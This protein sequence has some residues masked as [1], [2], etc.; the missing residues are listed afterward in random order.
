MEGRE[1]DDVAIGRRW[2][3]LM[4]K[5]EPLYRI[6]PPIK[7]TMLDKALHACMGN[8]GVVPQIHEGWRRL[9]RSKGGCGEAEATDL[10]LRRQ[11]SK[12]GRSER[13]RRRNG[14]GK[15]MVL[16]CKNMKGEAATYR[17]ERGE[18]ANHP[19]RFTRSLRRVTSPPSED[20]A[21]AI[22]SRALEGYTG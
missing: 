1:R 2:R 7:K 13:R 22:S 4:A 3:I 9:W 17:T 20:C 18:K 10:G 15:A 12:H 11:I 21:H 19:P 6:S 5:L 8:I 14:D 16:V